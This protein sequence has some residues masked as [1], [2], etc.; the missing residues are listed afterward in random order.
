MV[1]LLAVEW[2][3]VL[4]TSLDVL[5]LLVSQLVLYLDLR[6]DWQKLEGVL[7]IQ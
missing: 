7:Y 5:L 1:S 4:A 2:P 6:L 3:M